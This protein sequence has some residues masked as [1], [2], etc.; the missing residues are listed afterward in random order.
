[1]AK[2]RKLTPVAEDESYFVSMTDLMVGMLFIF[3][4]MLMAFALNLRRSI[5]LSKLRLH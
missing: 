4:I 3:I 1:M 2:P 5:N